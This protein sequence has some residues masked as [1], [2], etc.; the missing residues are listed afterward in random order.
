MGL[1][2]EVL[3]GSVTNPGAALTAWTLAPGDTLAVRAFDPGSGAWLLNAWGENDTAGRLRVKSP[4]MHDNVQGIRSVIAPDSVRPLYPAR[5]KARIYSTDTLVVEQSGG[6]GE[7]D[8]GALLLYYEN[9]GG[10]A[11]R[12]ET[13][14]AI[15]P[16]II[17]YM[18]LEQD[19]NTAATAGQWGVAQPINADFDQMKADTDYAL[20][21]YTLDALVTAIGVTGSDTGNLRVGGPGCVDERVTAGWF[22]DLSV[23]HS[24]PAIPVIGSNNRAGTVFDLLAEETGAARSVA[25]YFAR[26]G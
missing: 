5:T 14:D 24:M 20:L 15:A 26:L 18:T 7:I 22:A 19:L 9:L 8:V 11:A 23:A 6:G 1:A 25:L 13:W 21:G 3:G 12:L 10:T 2:M 16:R 4:R 17:D